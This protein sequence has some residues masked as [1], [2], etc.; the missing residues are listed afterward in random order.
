MGLFANLHNQLSRTTSVDD[1]IRMAVTHL[2]GIVDARMMLVGGYVDRLAPAVAKALAYC[3][4]LVA[5]IPGPVDVNAQTFGRDPLV[6]ALFAAPAD[7]GRMLAMSGEAQRFLAGPEAEAGDAFFALI[8]MRRREK[9]VLSPALRGDMIGD[10][11]PRRLLYFADHTIYAPSADLGV[12]RHRLRDAAFDSLARSFAASLESRRAQ[13]QD[14]RSEWEQERARSHVADSDEAR[15]HAQRRG[16]IEGRLAEAA[17][18]LEPAHVLE[19]LAAWLAAP[20]ASLRLD[21]VAV[22]VDSLGTVV[23]AASAAVDAQ[24]LR[25]PV[26]VGRDRRRWVVLLTRL[27]R[28]DAERARKDVDASIRSLII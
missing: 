2:V 24:T 25:L 20:E 4:R 23:G 3:A 18:S 9:T 13:R 26:L 16:E 14:L 22:T 28:D 17:A 8:G 10:E 15:R 19:A 1:D 6:H 11:V 5:A 27:Q 12:A 7:I 21:E